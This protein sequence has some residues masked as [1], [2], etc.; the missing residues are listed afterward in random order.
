[1]VF[2]DGRLYEPDPPDPETPDADPPAG[3]SR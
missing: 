2:I 1:M 3:A